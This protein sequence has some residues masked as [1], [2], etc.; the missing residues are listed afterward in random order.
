MKKTILVVDDDL[1]QKDLY[2]EVFKNKGYEVLSASDGLEGLE[3]ALKEKPDLVFTAI[4]M[5]RMDGFEFIR[6]L[7][8]N[9]STARTPVMMF[10][11][12]G[13]EEDRKKAEKLNHITFLV[14]GVDSPAEILV[15]I[16]ELLDQ[17]SE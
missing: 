2:V 5:P 16:A 6:N 3:T 14:K 12:L 4:I 11:H 7:R 8:N 17:P 9:I 1:V 10:S 13:R 15:K